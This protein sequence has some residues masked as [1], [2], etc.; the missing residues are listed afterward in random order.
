MTLR[1][2][3]SAVAMLL[4]AG[5]ASAQTV[6]IGHINTFSG[7]LA[8]FGKVQ[9]Q[10]VELALQHLGGK[11]GGLDVEMIYVDDQLKPDVGKQLAK[12]LILQDK[13]DFITGITF[14]NVLAAAQTEMRRGK[15]FAITTNAGWS[16]MAGKNCADNIFSTSWNNDQTPEA[17]GKLMQDE[18]VEDVYM[19]APNYQAG[20]NMISGFKRYYKGTTVGQTLVPLGH[21]DYAVE[22]ANIKAV[23]PKAVFYFLPGGMGIAFAKQWAAAGLQ[24]K[25]GLF[26]VFSVDWL[27][28]PALGELAIGNFHTAFWSPDLDNAQNKR[29]VADFQKKYDSHAEMYSAQSYDAIFLIDSAIR[30]VKGDLSD[31][32][33]IR[34]ALRAA[35]FKSVR[36]KFKFNTNHIPIQNFYKRE[37]VAGADGKPMV[38]NRGVVF[39][40]HKDAYY[41]EC[42][43]KW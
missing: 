31:R 6:K 24:G 13:V 28:I 30:A 8:I 25:I 17:M 41:K 32:D 10:G 18:G 29:F 14:S 20:K 16:G 38:V 11:V 39:K 3:M 37:V 27:T 23:N 5:V 9:K 36:G 42:K 19:M 12:K 40:D 34:N 21:N 1:I 43:M 35:N 7:R 2:L 22:I 33:G 15:V 26:S 4:I